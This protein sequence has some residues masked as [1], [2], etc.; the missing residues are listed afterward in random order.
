MKRRTTIRAPTRRESPMARRNAIL[1][2]EEDS[3]RDEGATEEP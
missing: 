3:E 1:V 2:H